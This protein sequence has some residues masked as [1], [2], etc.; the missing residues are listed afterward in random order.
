MGMNTTGCFYSRKTEIYMHR[1]AGDEKT[2]N[3]ITALFQEASDSREDSILGRTAAGAPYLRTMPGVHIS[4]SHSGSWW[5]CAA[6]G[7][8]VGIDLEFPRKRRNETEEDMAARLC[9][10]GER[11]FT[12]EEADWISRGDRVK[13]F[14]TLWTAREAYVK[15]LG[16]GVTGN[17]TQQTVLSNA[18]AADGVIPDSWTAQGVCFRMVELPGAPGSICCLCTEEEIAGDLRVVH[19]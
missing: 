6:S 12:S 3:L 4:V 11:F 13:R 5:L 8:P 19:F 18:F 1:L 15:Y 9:R 2:E 7:T 16:T 14:L 10:L 17:F